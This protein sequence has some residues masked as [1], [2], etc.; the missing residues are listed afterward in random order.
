MMHCAITIATNHQPMPDRESL[1]RGISVPLP[2]A[3]QIHWEGTGDIDLSV[4]KNG[5]ERV[6][7]RARKRS[8]GE[9][10]RDETQGKTVNSELFLSPTPQPGKYDEWSKSFCDSLPI[11][12]NRIAGTGEPGIKDDQ[13]R[14]R[15]LSSD[16]G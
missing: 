15:Q 14:R 10:M 4:V 5:A 6:W 1:K 11:G 3:A 2:L 12:L 9:L 7:Y 16:R 13:G 8:W